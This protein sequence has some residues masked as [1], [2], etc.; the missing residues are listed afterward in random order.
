MN[1]D[2]VRGLTQ[3]S[4]ILQAFC[5]P[6]VT[7]ESEGRHYRRVETAE[8]STVMIESAAEDTAIFQSAEEDAVLVEL[9]EVGAVIFGSIK[10]DAARVE[11]ILRELPAEGL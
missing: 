4:V 10:P 2:I 7:G 11:G 9:A 6:R 8:G 1:G 3:Q 5:Q